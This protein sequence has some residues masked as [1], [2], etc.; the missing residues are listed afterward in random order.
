MCSYR[1]GK[2]DQSPK[3]EIPLVAHHS[4]AGY[5]DGWTALPLMTPFARFEIGVSFSRM[6]LPEKTT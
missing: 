2:A 6:D 1:D 5:T 4:N 3:L